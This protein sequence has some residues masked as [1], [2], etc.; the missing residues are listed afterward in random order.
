MTQNFTIITY[1]KEKESTVGIG[2][3][4]DIPC[5]FL[6]RENTVQIAGLFEIY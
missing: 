5:N 4:Q 1:A 2:K 3:S 6:D